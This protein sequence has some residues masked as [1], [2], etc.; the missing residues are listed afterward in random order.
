MPAE[1]L[2]LPPGYHLNAVTDPDVTMLRRPDGTVV[3]IFGV[4]ADLQEIERV[5]WEDHEQ[6]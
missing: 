5:A 1:E 4:E 3:A 2:R 6:R